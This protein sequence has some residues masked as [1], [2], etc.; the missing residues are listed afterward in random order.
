MGPRPC[1]RPRRGKRG[2]G[3]AHPRSILA[4]SSSCCCAVAVASV[5]VATE[6]ATLLRGGWVLIELD[7]R[8]RVDAHDGQFAGRRPSWVH[9]EL[10]VRTPGIGSRRGSPAL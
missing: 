4:L 2:R 3:K 5:R 9:V 6:M 7:R 10:Q 1:G 8:C